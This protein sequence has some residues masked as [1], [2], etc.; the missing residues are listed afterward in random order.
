MSINKT[1]MHANFGDP[2]LRDRDLGTLKPRKNW[3]FCGQKFINL[4]I[5]AQK[6]LNIKY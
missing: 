6:R 5:R 2:R 3:Q 1:F 4:F